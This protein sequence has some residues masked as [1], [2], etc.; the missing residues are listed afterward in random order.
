MREAGAQAII[1][2]CPFCYL[3]F[4]L[5]QIEVNSIFKD[6]IDEPFRIPVIYITQ[7]FDYAFGKDPY[8]F[9]LLRPNSPKGTPPFIPT[10]SIFENYYEE[11]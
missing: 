3:Q 7:L 5:G 1:V 9:G 2:C 4:D 6:E 8:R 10:A 11:P